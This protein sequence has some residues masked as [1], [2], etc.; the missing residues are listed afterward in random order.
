MIL[1]TPHPVSRNIPI[2]ENNNN[3][4]IHLSDENEYITFDGKK[5]TESEFKETYKKYEIILKDKSKKTIYEEEEF[6]IEYNLNTSI[7]W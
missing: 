2:N 5:M 4:L 6:D 3:F 1:S 7:N